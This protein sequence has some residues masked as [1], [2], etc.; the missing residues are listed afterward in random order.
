[1]TVRP[2]LDRNPVIAEPRDG[3]LV[4][5]NK[6]GDELWKKY[7][8]AGFSPDPGG[9]LA[10]RDRLVKVQDVDGNGINEVLCIFG[11]TGSY[12]PFNNVLVCY[13]TD[14]TERWK[15]E[16]HRSMTFGGLPYTDDYRFYHM[17]AGDFAHS[18]HIEVMAV[19]RHD[20]WSPNVLLR[21]NADS[22]KVLGEFWQS[23]ELREFD[24]R[25]L[26]HDGVDE[27]IFGGQNNRLQH[28]CLAVF[29]P[30]AIAG[31]SP[32]PAGYY[33][34]GIPAGTE[35][36]YI[37]FP[38]SDL[39]QFAS[40]V[41]NEVVGLRTT[42]DGMTEV[43]VNEPVQRSSGTLYYYFDS[44]M[45]CTSVRTSDSFTASHGQLEREGKL[46]TRLDDRYFEALRKAVEYWNG[47]TFVKE[48]TVNRHY[49]EVSKPPPLP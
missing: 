46:S 43:I 48:A 27:L 7:I 37:L 3:F 12:F 9:N 35:K 2:R 11:W 24:A 17:E 5:S 47:D 16:L 15:Y 19:A 39:K 41:T 44:T 30:R 31:S 36:Y 32:G 23:G 40:D 49:L 10:H 21:V 1:M 25:D 45:H 4:V 29:D 42:P 14:G 26:D 38:A 8:G 20:P 28:A 18:G 33:P 6:H 34:P 22:G 13:N